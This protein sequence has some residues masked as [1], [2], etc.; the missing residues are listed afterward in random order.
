VI[1][2]EKIDHVHSQ[3]FGIVLNFVACHK[4]FDRGSKKRLGLT[5]ITIA[6]A[7]ILE[8]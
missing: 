5:Q 2:L 3:L 4:F 8:E 7:V 6:E 1:N